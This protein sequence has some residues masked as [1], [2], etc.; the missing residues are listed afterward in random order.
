MERSKK[1]VIANDADYIQK[2]VAILTFWKRISLMLW[3]LLQLQTRLGDSGVR[4]RIDAVLA[5]LTR[6]ETEQA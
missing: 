6:I 4:K 1:Y 5:I 2:L 3:N